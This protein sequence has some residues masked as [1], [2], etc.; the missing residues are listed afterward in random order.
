MVRIPGTPPT[1]APPAAPSAVRA[2]TPG[3]R[4]PRLWVGLVI[5]AVSVVAG[6]KLVGAADQ[7][8]GVWATASDLG[9]GDE[10]GPDDLVATR[11]HFAETDD[12]DGYFTVDEQLPADLELTRGVGAGE[13]L[14]RAAV[15][16]AGD[17]GTLE[18]PVAVDAE[19]VPGSVRSGSVVDIYLVPSSGPGP[20]GRGVSC[21]RDSCADLGPALSAVTVV[22]A[23]ALD[24]GFAATGKRQLVLA[25][26]EQDARAFF[27]LLGSS[28]GP[29]ITVVRRG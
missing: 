1:P 22:D 28:E 29:V 3:W 24:Q 8:V 27:A 23:P 18:V 2:A 9:A 7:T 5:V 6:A 19:Q 15:G 11:V 20:S 21:A 13:L 25:V 12:L 26:D 10:V 17:T 4:D 16:S 14:P